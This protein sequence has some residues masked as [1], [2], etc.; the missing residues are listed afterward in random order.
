MSGQDKIKSNTDAGNIKYIEK[1]KKLEYLN[2][3]DKN[4][5]PNLQGNT[6][7]VIKRKEGERL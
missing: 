6:P 1:M 7:R 5:K 4:K 3:T 2:Y